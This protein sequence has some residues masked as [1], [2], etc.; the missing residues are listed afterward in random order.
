MRL[1]LGIVI[2]LVALPLATNRIW[3]LY[4]LIRSGQATSGRLDHPARRIRTELVEVFGQRK[5]LRWS[6]PGVAHFFTFWGFLVLFLTIIETYGALFDEKYALPVIGHWA[7]VG[8]I[9]DLFTLAVLVAVV[10][11][12]VLRVRS[13]P[14]RLQ[15]ASRFY[16]SHNGVA[17][18]V[19]A[20]IALVMITLM[21]YR[22][23]Q[24]NTGNFPYGDSWWAFTS[25]AVAVALSP[26]SVAANHTI[27]TVFLLGQVAV[28]VAFLVV[29]VN[30]KHLHIGTAP[31]NVLAKR[32]PKALGPLLPM[33]SGG[34]PIDFED[35]D[36]D[37][38]FGRGTIA[39]FTWKGM[40]DFAT[41]T[42]CGRCQSQCPAWS[43]DKPLSPKLVIMN[44]RDHLF[45]AA[46]V[47]LDPVATADGAGPDGAGPDG[48]GPDGTAPEVRPLV[49]PIGAGGV[50]DP[51]VLWACTTCGA[52]VEECPVDIEH[53]DHIVDMRRNQVLMESA[54]PNELAGLFRN[55]ERNGNPWGLSPRMRLDW[56]KDLPFPVPQVG[57]DVEDLTS[58][59]YLFWVGCAG[60]LD[61]RAK[62]T[63]RAVAELLHTA[64]VSFAV[65]GESESCTGDSARRAGNEFLFQ[66]MAAS[67]IEVLDEAK[68]TKI[69]VT[70][71]H[72][73]NTLANEYP[74]LG[75]NYQVVHHTQLLNR[76]VREG[77]LTP[78]AP[79]EGAAA[80]Q[81][82]YHDPCYLG[83]HNNVYDPPR[84]LIGALPGVEFTE[85]PRHGSQS[86]CCGAGGSR[87]WLEETIGTRINDTRALEAVDTGADTIAAACPFCVTMLSDGVT[88]AQSQGKA[89]TDVHVTD[90]AQLLLDAVHRGQA[91]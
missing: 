84:E 80:E 83:R 82:T 12:S 81:V 70:C 11:F 58:V 48:A 2:T 76:L 53:V 61:D 62:K 43:T 66:T 91:D 7:A 42:E 39:D 28:V 44:L 10:V 21:L 6:V 31:I 23:A 3:W 25:K 86:F 69:V 73:L 1:A 59:D 56:A 75:G 65:L 38:T 54:F 32:Q 57:V 27:E 46:P 68:A 20:L 16:G 4:R 88:E 47:L 64:G 36:E 51:D 35:P 8:F 9:E 24:I 63:T 15:R 34:K 89:G 33:E 17:W 37:A 90:V 78:V 45:D 26:L 60:A 49:G 50:I 5:L 71:A 77:R 87:M 19:L 29:V 18:L 52:C 13:A 72:C 85:M 55:L 41:C 40:L 22:G 14:E 74:Q 79:P 30:S 67:N